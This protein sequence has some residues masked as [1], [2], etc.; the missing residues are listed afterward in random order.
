MSSTTSTASVFITP[1]ST[2]LS[3][4]QA[5][6][7]NPPSKFHKEYTF[8]PLP[9]TS[10]RKIKENVLASPFSSRP[11]SPA[12][13]KYTYADVP[14][15][16]NTLTSHSTTTSPTRQAGLFRRPSEPNINRPSWSL[17][18]SGSAVA[19]DRPPSQLD[20]LEDLNFGADLDFSLATQIS[21]P[22][23]LRNAFNTDSDSS[24][25]DLTSW[26]TDSLI[27]PPSIYRKGAY[28]NTQKSSEALGPFFVV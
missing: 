10:S 18:A 6:A 5:F 1:H 24:E 14:F 20:F 22:K 8:S 28:I 13:T 12:Y 26:Q 21:T 17:S 15:T 19:F 7:I 25:D 2:A 9:R 11:C 4:A 3:K 27:S 16:T 23:M